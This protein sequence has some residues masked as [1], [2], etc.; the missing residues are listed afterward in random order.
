MTPVVRDQLETLTPT[1]P[2]GGPMVIATLSCPQP[3]TTVCRVTGS[4]DLVTAPVL[5][6]KVIEAVHDGQP[7]IVL[8]LSAVAVLDSIGLHAVFEAL[9]RYDIEGHLAVVADSRSTAISRP[10]ISAL[11]EIVDIHHDLASALRACA[12]ASIS[13]GG[14]HRAAATN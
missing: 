6:D 4:V 3:D 8:D 9:D 11:G 14:R 12:R 7:H 10:D 2:F 5:A 1:S 13:S